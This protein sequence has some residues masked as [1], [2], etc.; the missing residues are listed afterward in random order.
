[1]RRFHPVIATACVLGAGA[2]GGATQA[3]AAPVASASRSCNVPSYPGSGYFTSLTVKRT[4]CRFGRR[5]ALA[6]YH[7]RTQSGP[8]G[9]CHRKWVKGY[10]CKEVRQSIAVE[11]DGRV[12]CKRGLKRVV[13]TYQQNL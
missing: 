2:I 3:P 5:L 8:A 7:C 13:H 9:R 1:M 6:Y 12:T 4:T 10:R 11:I